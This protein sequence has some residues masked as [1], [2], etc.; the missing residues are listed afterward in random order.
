MDSSILLQPWSPSQLSPVCWTSHISVLFLVGA[1]EAPHRRTVQCSQ[2][3]FQGVACGLDGKAVCALC[4]ACC[5][6]KGLT[7]GSQP[8]R[9]FRIP[10]VSGADAEALSDNLLG[11]GAQSVVWVGRVNQ[12][13]VCLCVCVCVWG[14]CACVC[15]YICHVSLWFELWV[16]CVRCVSLLCQM[17]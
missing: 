4:H 3:C 12:S 13:C 7:R 14:V 11:M 8:C 6:C 10:N 1:K 16:C 5:A 15:L 9:A 2:G 17:C